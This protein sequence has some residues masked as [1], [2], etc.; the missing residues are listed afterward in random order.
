MINKI[1]NSLYK[2]KKKG[3]LS[4]LGICSHEW[5]YSSVTSNGSLLQSKAQFYFMQCKYCGKV[6]VS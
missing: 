4:F 1:F 2:E 3:V 6:K 5:E